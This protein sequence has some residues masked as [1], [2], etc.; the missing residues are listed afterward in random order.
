[1]SNCQPV[2]S[3]PGI[4]P[5]HA[6]KEVQWKKLPFVFRNLTVSDGSEQEAQQQNI[7][8]VNPKRQSQHQQNSED[9]LPNADGTHLK[10]RRSRKQKPVEQAAHGQYVA[11]H[12]AWAPRTDK[13]ISNFGS[14]CR[15]YRRI[16]FK[17][18]IVHNDLTEQQKTMSSLRDRSSRLERTCTNV[19]DE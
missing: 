4:P 10:I 19:E 1:M 6:S 14:I 13:P 8:N 11:Q 16:T 5:H 18:H 9:I 2:S 12:S 7:E 17:P 15:N 3:T